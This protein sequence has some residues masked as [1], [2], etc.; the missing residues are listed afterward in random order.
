M[1]IIKSRIRS[2]LKKI[3][4]IPDKLSKNLKKHQNIKKNK[5]YLSFGENCLTDNILSR[6]DIKSYSTPY[7]SGRS[8][9]EYILQIEKDNFKNF[10]NPEY[11]KYDFVEQNKV[12]RLTVYN[13]LKN[14]YQDLCMHGFEFTHHDVLG[15]L[16]LRETM[17]R[18]Y[19]RLLN[20]NDKK[21][22]IFYHNRFGGNT[23]EKMLIGHLAELKSIYTK[24]CSSVNIFM[25]TQIIVSNSEERKV[26]HQIIDGIHVYKFYTLNVWAGT[27]NEIFWARCDDDLIE[28][29]INDAKK[30]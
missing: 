19:E 16:K 9:I 26:E 12:V 28:T 27:D 30:L 22:C 17:K 11:M 2:I 6:Y 18:R 13:E 25:F 23:D 20:I 29:M 1:K 8:N 4:N 10:L 14:K 15:N 3:K 21:L 24:R 7:S 5:L